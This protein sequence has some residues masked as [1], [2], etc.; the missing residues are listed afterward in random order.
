MM[1]GA[2]GMLAP[3]AFRRKHVEVAARSGCGRRRDRQGARV[4]L[5]GSGSER[6]RDGDRAR[7]ELRAGF[8]GVIGGVDPAAIFHA[9]IRADVA[10]WDGVLAVHRRA[11]GGGWGWRF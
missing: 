3:R 9:A 1:T 7:S 4:F 2:R 6:R 10:V 8:V 5:A 11:V